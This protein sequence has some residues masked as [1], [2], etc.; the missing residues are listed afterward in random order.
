M[1]TSGKIISIHG[2][3]YVGTVSAACFAQCGHTVVGVDVQT[4]K[5]DLINRGQAPVVE[6]GLEAAVAAARRAERLW[7]TTETARA[8]ALSDVSMICV[9]TPS[10]PNG[11]LDLSA[12]VRAV[13]GIGLALKQKDG[14]HIV[15]VRSTVFPGTID[16]VVR[17]VLEQASRKTIGVDID[18][19]SN[20]EFLREGSA[21]QDF[22]QPPRTVIG[23]DREAAAR[24]VA[25]L[26]AGVDAALYVTPIR[27]AEM[28][29]YVDNSWHAV[30]VAF[31]NEIGSVCKA[32]GVDSH[33]VM[34]LFC[35][36]T[37]L[38]L[39]PS[40]LR[41]GF[42]FGGSCLPKDLRALAYRARTLDVELPLLG[43][44]LPSNRHQVERGL[45]RILARGRK[46][47]GVLGIAFKAGT[48]DLRESPLCEV[49]EH[50]IGKGFDLRLYDRSINV[51]NLIGANR[52]YAEHKIGHLTR[53]MVGSIDEVLA[54]ADLVVIG[55]NDPQFHSVPARLRPDQILVDL[56]RIPET[57]GLGD[58]YD[59][60]NW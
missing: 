35:A 54:H 57:N 37:K 48:D 50:L 4:A 1:N 59:G 58:R 56:V 27:V 36:D 20:P 15:V 19:C 18:V 23:A 13:E 5:V 55:N 31:A 29:K 7:A 44:V 45:R 16:T 22:F 41:P 9:G 40:Y 32:V 14:H 39:S 26:Y 60:I 21:I 3:G 38:N 25:A 30:K 11:N 46:R 8:V 33:R 6:P 12:L 51:A 24:T 17:P 47:I 34:D 53:L 28:I 49:I 2:L 10:L 43:S 42:A 52:D